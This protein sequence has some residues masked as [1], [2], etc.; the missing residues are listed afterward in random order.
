MCLYSLGMSDNHEEPL[1]EEIPEED[2]ERTE[3]DELHL[4]RQALQQEFLDKSAVGSQR[5]T[6]KETKEHINSLIPEALEGLRRLIKFA[7]RDATKLRA[8]TW[9]L[10]NALSLKGIAN[11]DDPLV[12]IFE[13]MNEAAKSNE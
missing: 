13:E 7:D 1:Y 11:T 12:E 8:C 4:Y 9:V 10:E 6:A 5:K 3:Q 2:V